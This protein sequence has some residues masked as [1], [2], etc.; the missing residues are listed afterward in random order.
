MCGRI[1][2]NSKSSGLTFLKN[3]NDFHSE[4]TLKLNR[5]VPLALSSRK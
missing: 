2:S 4:N 1:P 3:E 5:E